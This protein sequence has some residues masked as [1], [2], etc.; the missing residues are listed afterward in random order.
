[1][2][3]NP[4]PIRK[5]KFSRGRYEIGYFGGATR[6]FPAGKNARSSSA[7][8]NTKKRMWKL[9]EQLFAE[10]ADEVYYR[11]LREKPTPDGWFFYHFV[12]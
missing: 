3:L 2:A 4:K 11:D 1:M 7:Y 6:W 12:K 8:R 10:G 5:R 9:M